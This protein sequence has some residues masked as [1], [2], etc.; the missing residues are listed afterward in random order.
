[1][2]AE[3]YK[4]NL[5]R[6]FVGHIASDIDERDERMLL[7]RHSFDMGQSFLEKLNI[8]VHG[9]KSLSSEQTTVLVREVL[10]GGGSYEKSHGELLVLSREGPIAGNSHAP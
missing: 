9:Y 3:L 1:M 5:L 2:F 10:C 4:E 8:G 6:L 7:R